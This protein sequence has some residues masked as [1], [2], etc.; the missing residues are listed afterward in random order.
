MKYWQAMT[1]A[2]AMWT[3]AACGSTTSSSS[4][5]TDT[6]ST[7]DAVG[8]DTGGGTDTTSTLD[9]TCANAD[10]TSGSVTNAKCSSC[11]QSNCLTEFMACGTDADGCAKPLENVGTCMATACDDAS[12]VQACMTAFSNTSSNAKNVLDCI[13]GKCKSDCPG[14]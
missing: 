14:F 10:V 5:T 6:G 7:G 3:T 13:T 11:M 12:K 1:A 8:A 4:N 2:A 9:V